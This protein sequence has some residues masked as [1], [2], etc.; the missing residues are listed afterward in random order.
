MSRFACIVVATVS[1]VVWLSPANGHHSFS[2]NFDVGGSAELRGVLTDIRIRNPHSLLEVEVIGDDGASER[3]VVETHAVP[4]LARVG[5]TQETFSE[6]EEVIVRG[7][8]SRRAD[9]NLIFGLQFV[10]TD[11]TVFEWLPG[12]LVADG[13]LAGELDNVA[14]IGR[15]RFE[16][17]WGYTA[18]PNPHASG[19]SPMPL[20]AAALES[21]EQFDPFNTSAMR[22]IPPNIPGILYVPYLYGI[23]IDDDAVTLNHEYFAISRVVPLSDDFVTTESSGMFG[24]GRARFEGQNLIVET[25]EYP[26]LEAGMAT[27]FDQNGM[28]TDLP[29][30]AEKSVT[31]VYSL[32]DDG[33]TLIIEYTVTDP[34]FL[35]EPYTGRTELARLASGTEIVDFECDPEMAAETSAQDNI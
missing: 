3:W 20:T 2:V 22:C 9:R 13:G 1:L 29:S 24:V 6:G 7:W 23:E 26:A 32:S 18:D 19:E 5:F 10:K 25:R 12:D 15:E 35:T 27:A 21:R 30:S 16:A 28:G 33:S 34:V 11:G 14:R 17:V 4:L 8:P 31:E